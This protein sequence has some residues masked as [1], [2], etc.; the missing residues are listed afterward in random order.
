VL[1][2]PLPQ[3]VVPLPNEAARAAI[4][5][6]HL[7]KVPLASR[8]DREL[9]CEALAKIT[10]GGLVAQLVLFG[11]ALLCGCSAAEVK[12]VCT[13]PAVCTQDAGAAAWHVL[14]ADVAS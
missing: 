11:G 7:R 6:V 14:L 3:V 1:L 5:G 2:S 4:L 10:A 12:S 13:W 9:A 8:H